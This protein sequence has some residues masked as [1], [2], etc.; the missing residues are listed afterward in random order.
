M[1]L[2]AFI[3]IVKVRGKATKI[4]FVK[5]FKT[6]G[7]V[8]FRC[9][10]HR[11]RWLYVLHF[12]KLKRICNLLPLPVQGLDLQS[13]ECICA[14]L[15]NVPAPASTNHRDIRVLWDNADHRAQ[16][17]AARDKICTV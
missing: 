4:T 2:E 17:E 12:R 11:F 1:K 14:Q 7:V 5:A 6:Q 10:T 15:Q 13:S 9:L 16:K 3:S 8:F